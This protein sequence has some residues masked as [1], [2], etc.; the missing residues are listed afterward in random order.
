MTF[1]ST[2][3]KTSNA[4]EDTSCGGERSGSKLWKMIPDFPSGYNV[5]VNS[6]NSFATAMDV[7]VTRAKL[8]YYVGRSVELWGGGGGSF[9]FLPISA[10]APS[11]HAPFV[12]PND[13]LLKP[14]GN[15][16]NAGYE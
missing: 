7:L 2:N 14:N 13:I 11:Q 8:S 10:P 15:T 9:M 12:R 1:T 16:C 4:G 3:G 5:W 6:I